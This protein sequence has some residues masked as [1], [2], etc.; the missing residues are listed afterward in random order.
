[1]DYIGD[2]EHIEWKLR[3]LDYVLQYELGCYKKAS[4]DKWFDKP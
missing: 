1:M 4:D 2:R 3:H